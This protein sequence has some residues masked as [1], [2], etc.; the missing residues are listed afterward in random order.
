VAVVLVEQG[1]KPY[2]EYISRYVANGSV[3]VVLFDLGPTA[4]QAALN[5]GWDGLVG[6]FRMSDK[7]RRRFAARLGEMGDGVAQRW[8][9]SKRR[10]RVFMLAQEATLLFN[11]DAAGNY[12]LEP[13][14]TGAL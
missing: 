2:D 8:V 14:S 1:L 9:E 5:L 6:V 4:E 3:A 10:G 7:T 13:G 12:S 11:R